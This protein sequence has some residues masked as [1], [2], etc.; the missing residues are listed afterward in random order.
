MNQKVVEELGSYIELQKLTD[1]ARFFKT[2]KGEYGEGDKFLGI[3]VPNIRKVVKN[4]RLLSLD[5]IKEFL[6]SPYHEHRMFA[7]LVLTC[8]YE[9][10]RLQIPQ[11]K[12]D[13]FNFYIEHRKQIN[14]WDLID[15]T[16]PYIIGNYLYDKDRTLLY[17]FAKSDELWEKRIAIISTFAFIKMNQFEDTLSIADILLNDKHDLIHKGVGWAI[18][19]VGNKDQSVMLK[20]LKPRYKNIPRTMLR[21]A[22]EKL[23]EDTRQKFLKGFV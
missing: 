11:T 9:S 2:A 18:R 13:I 12:E 20:Y 3:R 23:D 17:D 22:I 21:Y 14:N 16:C 5:E 7:V 8:Q 4:H 15:V 19:N 6:Y 10:K 1:L